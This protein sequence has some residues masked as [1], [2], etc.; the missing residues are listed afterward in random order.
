[1]TGLLSVG[2]LSELF[3]YIWVHWERDAQV[4]RNIHLKNQ[5]QHRVSPQ[6]YS[7]FSW[8]TLDYVGF[9]RRHA[10]VLQTPYT[11]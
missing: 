6:H 3:G 2:T 10:K 5:T 9:S 7:R 1:M 8:T 11:P 4:M